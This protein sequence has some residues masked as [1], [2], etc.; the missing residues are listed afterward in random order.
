MASLA[1]FI[2]AERGKQNT[3]EEQSP[4]LRYTTAGFAGALVALAM[5]C[6]V[7]YQSLQALRNEVRVV[8][9]AR[10]VLMQI[11]QLTTL[12]SDA[13]IVWR[14]YLIT[15]DDAQAREFAAAERAIDER[16]PRLL[17]LTQDDPTLQKTLATFL[18]LEHG[19][20]AAMRESAARREAH[21][22]VS[23]REAMA[24]LSR[25]QPNMAQLAALAQQMKNHE[26]DLLASSAGRSDASAA[27]T[28]ELV[29]V[30]TAL[31]VI[32]LALCFGALRNEA[33]R[34]A[35]TARALGKSEE[36]FRSLAHSAVDG[37]VSGDRAGRI[38]FWNAGAGAIFGYNEREALG[39]SI[40]ALAPADDR[41]ELL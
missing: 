39:M 14:S 3:A 30:G 36:R 20:L 2:H 12:C 9:H 18:A 6:T 37:I 23:A 35:G 19:D 8:D 1:P 27:E 29:V 34:H 32:I 24:L 38:V 33:T 13:V 5:I 7:A 16:G 25:G 4:H 11:E 17:A 22:P 10:E 21:E 40:T 15:G 28:G 41:R 26:S 31:S